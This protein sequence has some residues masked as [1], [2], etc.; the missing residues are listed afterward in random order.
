MI[1]QLDIWE[2]LD[3]DAEVFKFVRIHDTQHGWFWRFCHMEV[4]HEDMVDKEEVPLSAGF[5]FV[6]DGTVL[7]P[8]DYDLPNYSTTLEINASDKD[9]ECIPILFEEDSRG[10]H[11]I[12]KASIEAKDGKYIAG[13]FRNVDDPSSDRDEGEYRHR[14]P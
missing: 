10:R 4:E 1:A 3:S 12:N 7:F 5:I 6:V 8:K 14:S 13:K 9:H 2:M 11:I